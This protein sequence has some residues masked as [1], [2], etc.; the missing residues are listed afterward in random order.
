MGGEWRRDFYANDM[1]MRWPLPPQRALLLCIIWFIDN[2][3]DNFRWCTTFISMK[4]Q[5]DGPW[6]APSFAYDWPIDM[7]MSSESQYDCGA[8]M[9]TLC[10]VTFSSFSSLYCLNCLN[11]EQFHLKFNKKSEIWQIIISDY[12]GSL[13]TRWGAP[14]PPPIRPSITKFG[15]VVWL[16]YGTIWQRRLPIIDLFTAV[17]FIDSQLATLSLLR[18]T[19][20]LATLLRWISPSGSVASP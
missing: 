20:K 19:G 5:T 9:A 14:L 1:Q 11:T 2:I 10:G 17:G 12:F 7:Q 15:N 4:Y 6:R 16:I 18:I 8:L 3:F 13:E